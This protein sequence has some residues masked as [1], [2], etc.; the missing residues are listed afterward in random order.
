MQAQEINPAVAVGP[1]G[2]V[3]VVWGSSRLVARTSDDYGHSFGAAV[4]LARDVASAADL[5][6]AGGVT[7]VGYDDADGRITVS[8]SID[9]G[10]TW[11]RPRPLGPAYDYTHPTIIARGSRVFVSYD[12]V[13]NEDDQVPS[14]VASADR[15]TTWRPPVAVPP[16]I[17]GYQHGTW[18]LL[19]CDYATDED[20]CAVTLASRRS[21]RRPWSRPLVVSAP[22]DHQPGPNVEYFDHEPIGVTDVGQYRLV[23]Y[24]VTTNYSFPNGDAYGLV[25][26]FVRRIRL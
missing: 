14:I 13:L 17:L 23:L 9:H 4:L 25:D 5:A 22:S 21:D 6:I 16:G 26:L 20:D 3:T 10:R 1:A 11:V 19:A 15:G 12:A 2:Q 18:T 7:Y 8:R 24:A